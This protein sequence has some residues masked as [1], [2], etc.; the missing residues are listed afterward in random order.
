[1][2]QFKIYGACIALS[3]APILQCDIPVDKKLTP[4][5]TLPSFSTIA[6]SFLD[7]VDQHEIHQIPRSALNQLGLEGMPISSVSL[8]NH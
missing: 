1:M 8:A 7:E 2:L 6:T 5:C 3:L 4:N